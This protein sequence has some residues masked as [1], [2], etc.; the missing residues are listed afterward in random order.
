MKVTALHKRGSRSCFLAAL[1]L[2][3]HV[4]SLGDTGLSSFAHRIELA[5]TPG[6]AFYRVELPVAVHSGATRTDLA[7]LKVFN[8][9]GESVPFAFAA[10]AAPTEPAVRQA[11]PLFPLHAQGAMSGSAALDLQVRQGADG[12]LLRLRAPAAMSASVLQGYLMDSGAKQRA[13]QAIELDW[14]QSDVAVNTRVNVDSSEDLKQWRRLVDN[15][16]LLDLNFG[17]QRLRQ[18]DIK[19]D[20]PHSRYLRLEFV[21][22]P[23]ALSN[24]SV[25]LAPEAPEPVRRSIEAAGSAVAGRPLEYQFDLGAMVWAERIAFVLP[26]RNTVAPAELLARSGESEAWRPIAGTVVYRLADTGGELA[27]PPL[28]IAPTPARYWLL[29]L[30]PA[31]GGIGGGAPRVQVGY[32]P[33]HLVFVARGAGPFVLAYGQR[34]RAGEKSRVAANAL[35]LASLMPDYRPGA[36]WALPSARGGTSVLNNPAALEPRWSDHLDLRKLGLWA[37][38]LGAVLVLALMAWRLVGQ[39]NKRG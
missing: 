36:E 33:R 1:L 20:R 38:L 29:R 13:I 6:A 21:G 8:A 2:G 4:A 24:V 25:T 16:P 32:S 30:N 37:V 11:I 14:G 39:I 3:W 10:N 7:D 17:G 5:I 31:S 27:S 26:E 19:L 22:T 18:R 23:V 35:P 28:V 15:A 9:A 34:E 12:T